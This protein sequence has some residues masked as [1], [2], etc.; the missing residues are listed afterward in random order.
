[1]KN[2]QRAAHAE[3]LTIGMCA[4]DLFTADP[5]GRQVR[6]K[7]T[8]GLLTDMPAAK[9]YLTKRCDKAHQH[10]PFEGSVPGCD[11]RTALAQVCSSTCVKNIVAAVKLQ[12]SWVAKVHFWFGFVSNNSPVE[13]HP[14]PKEVEDDQIVE[15]CIDDVN[16]PLEGSRHS[17]WL[18]GRA[19]ILQ[20]GGGV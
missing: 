3:R 6:A 1:M 5:G 17:D 15:Y 9:V 14:R 2:V 11:R 12:K 4:C 7:K 20:G 10:D 18:R 19:H 8:T 13:E 16:G